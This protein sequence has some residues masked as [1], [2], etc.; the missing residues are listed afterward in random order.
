MKK[1]IGLASIATYLL[2]TTSS[3]ALTVEPPTNIG[4]PANTQP[5]TIITQA[6]NISY[7]VAIVI[8]LFF[9]ILG[10][11]NWITSGG[12]KEKVA[13]ARGTIVN[14]LIGLAVLALALV[15]ITV[16]GAILGINILQPGGFII[17]SLGGNNTGI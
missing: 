16:I 6:L 14:A 8:V 3:L 15:I 17:R 2:N 4:L 5:S 7:I 13:K 12:E 9:I 11:F 10:A 1:V